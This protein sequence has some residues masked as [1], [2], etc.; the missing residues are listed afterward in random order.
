MAATLRF[1]AFSR[2]TRLVFVAFFVGG[3]FAAE[4]F[5]Q[6]R[7]PN[8]Y[9][10][11][12]A[13]LVTRMREVGENL[14]E[15]LLESDDDGLMLEA[16]LCR[17]HAGLDSGSERAKSFD[18]LSALT[19][20]KWTTK[21]G[22]TSRDFVQR[23]LD[24]V[25]ARDSG[26]AFH[27]FRTADY[28]RGLGGDEWPYAWRGEAA[29]WLDLAAALV[30]SGQEGGAGPWRKAAEAHPA[31]A[32]LFRL[33]YLA[34]I[35][36][37][38][39]R[40]VDRDFVAPLL[41]DKLPADLRIAHLAALLR[42]LVR[43]GE[44]ADSEDRASLRQ[45][46]VA[47][48]RGEAHDPAAFAALALVFTA[49][50]AKAEREALLT[51]LLQDA[52]PQTFT[53]FVRQMN[54]G[55]PL[56]RE[57][58]F[59]KQVAVEHESAPLH[60]VVESL[61]REVDLPLWI[62]SAVREDASLMSIKRRGRWLDVLTAV[63][64]KSPHELAMFGDGVLWIGPADRRDAARELVRTS[65]GKVPDYLD[66]VGRKTGE[67][68][69]APTDVDFVA[70]PLLDTCLYLT[71]LRD[72]AIHVPRDERRFRPVTLRLRG[73]PL[74]LALELICRQAELEWDVFGALVV[75]ASPEKMENLRRAQEDFRLK[76]ARLE[77]AGSP[78][79]RK[80]DEETV[81][82]FIE[83][84]L[85]D[86]LAYLGD[87]HSGVD[88]EIAAGV[89]P[90]MPITANLAHA[91]LGWS[92]ELLLVEHGLTAR[93]ERDRLVVARRAKRP[94]SDAKQPDRDSGGGSGSAAPPPPQPR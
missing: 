86:V 41:E 54:F 50:E 62:D 64:E 8:R 12:R 80:L 94:E 9:V 34:A 70:I 30:D 1:A 16:A 49:P 44:A 37:R 91:P 10:R 59:G 90:D 28:F 6:A 45:Q 2:S 39:G 33:A 48:A 25:K 75:V 38:R 79:R 83:T 4:A 19:R 66:A 51:A 78:L 65:A 43:S 31:Q 61:A 67:T 22:E 26:Y 7:D 92:L 81:A 58:F 77:A 20:R 85:S 60:V 84:P 32:D 47:L 93:F 11:E 55:E 40:A 57:L 21:E 13:R 53:R 68:L 5:A 14:L 89:P 18:T 36:G 17:L 87:L 73:V 76:L 24:D 56:R 52:D 72:L 69:H 82:E 27:L 3:L 29:P 42:V 15:K 23:L 71:D 74:H 35:D 63:V 46:L 88:S